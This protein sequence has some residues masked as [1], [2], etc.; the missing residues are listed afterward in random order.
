[1]KLDLRKAFL[2]SL[3]NKGTF[4]LNCDG[5]VYRGSTTQPC[6]GPGFLVCGRRRLLLLLIRWIEG[7]GT[8]CIFTCSPRP[9]HALVARR[10][11]RR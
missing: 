5:N 6:I 4:P 7:S 10:L 8:L 1:M 3:P 11:T 9:R 2:H